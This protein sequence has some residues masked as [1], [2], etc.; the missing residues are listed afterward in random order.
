MDKE[1]ITTTMP[2]CMP[3]SNEISHCVNVM[4]PPLSVVIVF[5]VALVRILGYFD[6]NYNSN[7]V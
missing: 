6:E 1:S 5:V 2:A 7:K 4:L 3:G